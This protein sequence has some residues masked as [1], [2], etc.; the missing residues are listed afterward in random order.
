MSI[1]VQQLAYFISV[2][3]IDWSIGKY[4]SAGDV[5]VDIDWSKVVNSQEI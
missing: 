5:E 2:Q 4:T 3:P 1:Y